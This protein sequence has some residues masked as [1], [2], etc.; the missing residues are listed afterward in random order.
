[1][2]KRRNSHQIA[3]PSNGSTSS[4]WLRLRCRVIRATGSSVSSM[5]GSESRSGRVPSAAPANSAARR[6]CGGAMTAAT[7]APRT[8][9]VNES[10]RE[11]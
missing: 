4:E 6:W 7:A 9:W 8:I 10:I 1:L 11:C 2:P 5:T 3:V